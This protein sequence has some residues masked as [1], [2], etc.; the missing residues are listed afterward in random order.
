MS[1]KARRS[2]HLSVPSVS[3]HQG[4]V[5]LLLFQEHP[6]ARS[7]DG[8][9]EPGWFINTLFYPKHTPWEAQNPLSMGWERLVLGCGGLEGGF[10]HPGDQ[11]MSLDVLSPYL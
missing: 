4:G 6:S 1:D 11:G 5:A 2:A 9:N 3:Q 8:V 7:W 10:P